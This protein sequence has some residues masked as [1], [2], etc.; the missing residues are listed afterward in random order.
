[1]R[2]I[3]RTIVEIMERQQISQA[4]LAR[5]SKICPSEISRIV[6]GKR[7]PSVKNLKA[8][9]AALGVPFSYFVGETR[10]PA[11]TDPDIQSFY[12]TEYQDLP[13]TVKTWH[14][15]TLD[16]MRE[17]GRISKLNDSLIGNS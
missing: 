10:R 6:T 15:V 8:I 7:K 13:S 11:W 4:D 17:V 16:M 9:A 2:F 12:E 3:C 5:K 1:M 14:R